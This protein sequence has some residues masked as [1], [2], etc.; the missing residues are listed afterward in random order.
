VA[1]QVVVALADSIHPDIQQA[2]LILVLQLAHKIV[3]Q[4][5]LLI[6]V[7]VA[8]V[9]VQQVQLQLMV[10]VDVALRALY[11]SVIHTLHLQQFQM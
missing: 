9:L 4:M 11:L 8:A 7:G 5:Q 6:Q 10:L 2:H 3:A 1:V